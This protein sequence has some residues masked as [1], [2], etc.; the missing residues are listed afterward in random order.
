[1][2]SF[3]F[4]TT[5]L[6]CRRG[7]TV[8]DFKW[9]TLVVNGLLPVNNYSGWLQMEKSG[10]FPRRTTVVNFRWTTTVIGYR[11]RK[12]VVGFKWRTLVGGELQ[13]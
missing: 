6:G 5:A 13:V 2:V 3:R 12:I 9:R 7:T 4:R 11:W 8:F 1:M 10:G